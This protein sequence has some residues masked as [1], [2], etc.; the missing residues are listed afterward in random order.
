VRFF[1]ELFTGVRPKGVRERFV[2]TKKSPAQM[3]RAG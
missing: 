1:V 3:C 2:W